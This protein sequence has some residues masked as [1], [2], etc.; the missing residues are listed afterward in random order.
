MNM[1]TTAEILAQLE[2]IEV[3]VKLAKGL[4]E[5]G[6]MVDDPSIPR[7]PNTFQIGDF[8]VTDMFWTKN[9]CG[10]KGCGQ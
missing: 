10:P 2:R 4:V 9:T 6:Q 3:Q 8:V 1:K 5:S 7:I